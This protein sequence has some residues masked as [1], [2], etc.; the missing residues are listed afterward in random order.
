MSIPSC[1]RRAREHRQN[2]HQGNTVRSGYTLVLVRPPPTDT[3]PPNVHRPHRLEDSVHAVPGRDEIAW[4]ISVRRTTPWVPVAVHL[5][6]QTKEDRLAER[7]D[8]LTPRFDVRVE[9]ARC[10]SGQSKPR[11]IR[12]SRLP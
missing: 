1:T 2:A 9:I 10:D 12:R 11:L 8:A 5:V 6:H 3:K 4:S 7:P